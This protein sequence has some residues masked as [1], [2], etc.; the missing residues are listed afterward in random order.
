MKTYQEL[1]CRNKSLVLTPGKVTIL[2]LDN[3][4]NIILFLYIIHVLNLIK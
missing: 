4:H 3:I 2:L 1:F